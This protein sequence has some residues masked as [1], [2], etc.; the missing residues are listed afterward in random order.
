MKEKDIR[1]LT[2]TAL[3]AAVLCILGPVTVPIGPVPISLTSFVIYLFLFILDKREAVLACL[4]Y[5]L[6]GLAGLPV[7]SG[8]TGGVPKLLGPTGGFLIGYLPMAFLAG[9]ALGKWRNNRV[10]SVF[11]LE[12]ATWILYLFGTLW[13]CLSA[14]MTFADALKV[15]VYP[16]VILDLIKII[17]A[18]LLGPAIRKRLKS[19]AAAG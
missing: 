18:A 19:A 13:L 1:F 4:I 8:Y 17:A 7:F 11:L 14:K 16:F 10:V 2:G 15:A 6:I 3:M 12:A 9:L 5:L